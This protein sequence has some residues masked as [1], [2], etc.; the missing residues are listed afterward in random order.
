MFTVEQLLSI[1]KEKK[2]SDVHVTVG[3]PPRVRINGELVDLDYPKLSPDDCEKLIL[4]IMDDRQ[5]AMFKDRG[6]FDFSFSVPPICSLLSKC[7]LIYRILRS[8][9]GSGN[10][11]KCH[12]RH[13]P[14]R[15]HRQLLLAEG[16][17]F[18]WQHLFLQRGAFQ[19][20]CS[21]HQ[22][23]GLRICLNGSIP[24]L[25]GCRCPY[26]HWRE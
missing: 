23:R 10:N 18:P 4:D 11:R 19:Y 5:Q 25:S 12:P 2:A 1:A 16:K 8:V 13:H 26:R 20:H 15:F 22:R 17:H 9:H 7:N 24:V 21:R 3:L 14:C 6:E